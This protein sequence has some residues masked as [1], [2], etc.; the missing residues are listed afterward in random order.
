MVT[1]FPLLPSTGLKLNAIAPPSK[2]ELKW[3]CAGCTPFAGVPD[4]SNTKVIDASSFSTNVALLE[5]PVTAFSFKSNTVVFPFGTGKLKSSS[6]LQLVIKNKETNNK[7]K[8]LKF[9]M[10]F[11]FKIYQ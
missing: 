4:M 2:A 1:L 5:I 10:F 3:I 7:I 6:S 9:F 8:G 11:L